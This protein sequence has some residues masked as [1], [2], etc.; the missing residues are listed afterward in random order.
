MTEDN[1]KHKTKVGMYWTFLNQGATQVL[2]FMVGV[3]MARKLSPEDYGITAL[4]AVFFA[5]ANIFIGAG[6]GQ[7]LVRKPEVTNKDLSTA[8]YYSIIIGL[9]MYFV[10]FFLAPF[11]ADFYNTPVLTPLVR[12]SALTFLWGPLI[13]PQSVILQRKLDFKTPARISVTTQILGAI[14]GIAAAYNGLGLWALIIMTVVSSFLNLIQTWWAVR[15]RPTERWNKDSFRYLWGYGNKIIGSSLIDTLYN[16]VA[17]VFIGK[18][19]SPR[20]LGIYNR[21]NG[22]ATLPA[23]QIT[24]ILSNVTFPV[25]SKFSEDDE[26]LKRHFRR[27][28]KLSVFVA[29]PVFFLLIALAKPL[30]ICLVTEKWSACIILLQIICLERMWWPIQI[31]NKNVLYVKGRSDLILKVEIYKKTVLLLATIASL[32]FGLVIF[33]WCLIPKSIYSLF[34]NSYY[35]KRL[36]DLD[37]KDQIKDIMPSFL[38]SLFMFGTVYLVISFINN[39]YI[40]L[41]VGGSVGMIIYLCGALMFKFDE[42]HDVKYMLNRK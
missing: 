30:V 8:F 4:P 7:A 41:A 14:A 32:P 25:L 39:M 12:V 1:I 10:L 33:C 17:P 6:F 20:D 29:F 36:I 37:I 3:I 31:L 23:T 40:Q 11:I 27:M 2:A 42:L 16:N 13:T 28:I 15:W 22:Y 38:L 35:T 19:F 26:M 34:V 24:G 9:F 18:Y 5:V 21:A